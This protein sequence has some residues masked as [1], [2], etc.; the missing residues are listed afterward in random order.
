MDFLTQLMSHPVLITVDILI[1]TYIIYI[2]I[3]FARQSQA[4]SVLKGVVSIVG[5]K[6]IS[7]TVQLYAL[8][9]IIDQVINWGVIAMLIIF[10]PEIRRSLEKLGQNPL[11]NSK[12]DDIAQDNIE[13]MVE[14]I[15]YLAKRYIGA[16]IC[17]EYKSSLNAYANTGVPLNAKISSQ[18]L[19]NIFTPNTPL[20]D[21][22]VIIQDN[23]LAAASCVLPLSEN[24]AIPQE[25][26]TRHRAAIGLSELT[27]ALTIIVSEETGHISATHHHELHR[28]L[29]P[30]EL[31]QLIRQVVIDD[32]MQTG[33][34]PF[35]ERLK[36]VLVKF[37]GR[38]K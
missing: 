10:Q 19:I 3:N 29:T 23:Q 16:L 22:A 38:K 9:W 12:K 30:E 32:G 31:T 25:L 17:I 6:I 26:G 5:I 13:A 18:L 34:Q 8:N 14:A 33:Q 27:D 36:T 11:F 24:T 7:Q 2:L 1:V 4:V 15:T 35:K 37:G 21:G 20:H 28:Q